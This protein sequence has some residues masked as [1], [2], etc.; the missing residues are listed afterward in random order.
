MSG[1]AFDDL[2][3]LQLPPELL[4]QI[5][6]KSEDNKSGRRRKHLA[7]NFYMAPETWLE[8]A[9]AAVGSKSQLMAAL[10]LYRLWHTRKPGTDHV[11]ASNVKLGVSRNVKH[12]ALIAL[13][14]AGLIEV[15]A[16]GSGMAPR[17]K[18]LS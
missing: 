17:I 9:Y 12:R 10:R 3:G 14:G 6:P 16:G 1:D 8:D 13:E 2:R 4:V 11:V 7:G 15:K 18:V 5:K